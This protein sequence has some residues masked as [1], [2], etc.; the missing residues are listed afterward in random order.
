MITI[1]ELLEILKKDKIR[2]GKFVNNEMYD[3]DGARDIFQEG[4][5]LGKEMTL[6]QVIELI[7]KRVWSG[8]RVG[9]NMNNNEKA[10]ANA[11][12]HEIERGIAYQDKP[13]KLDWLIRQQD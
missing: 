3:G 13:E 4:W 10:I 8:E 9:E 2:V 11:E 12:M 5:N 7:K 6:E 1:R